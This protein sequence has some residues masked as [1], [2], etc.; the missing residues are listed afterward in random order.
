M[1]TKLRCDFGDREARQPELL[2]AAGR[3]LHLRG[4][5]AGREVH[6]SRVRPLGVVGVASLRLV[7]A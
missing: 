3:R 7:R 2:D 1:I 5:A 4:R 6:V